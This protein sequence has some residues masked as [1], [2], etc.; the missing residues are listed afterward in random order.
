MTFKK[1]T[2][3]KPSQSFFDIGKLTEALGQAGLPPEDQ[4]HVTLDGFEGPLD[5]LLVLARTQKVD[6]RSLSMTRLADQYLIFVH[7]A[8]NLRLELIAD[9]IVMAAWLAF[10]KS[11][12][13]LPEDVLEEDELSAE[14]MMERLAWHLARL[15]AFRTAAASLYAL[16]QKGMDFFARGCPE[17]I[18][19]RKKPVYSVTLY[20]LLKVYGH[21]KAKEKTQPLLIKPPQV[22]ALEDAMRRLSSLIGTRLEWTSLQ[23]FLP[24]G[25]CRRIETSESAVQVR[26]AWASTLAACLEMARHGTIDIQQSHAFAP[27]YIRKGTHVHETQD[28]NA[29]EEV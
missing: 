11:K 3:D 26:S 14:Q 4:M 19:L 6:L 22:Y 2:G 10:L 16:P 21:H 24:Q 15:E 25:L 20:D 12:L 18:E 9:Y 1:H 8:K 27:I 13:L 28:E 5:I 17:V 29:L 23:E 7:A